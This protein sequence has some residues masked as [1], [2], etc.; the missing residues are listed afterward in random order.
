M[1]ETTS[2]AEPYVC[3]HCDET[4]EHTH[5]DPRELVLGLRRRLVTVTALRGILL[6]AGLLASMLLLPP[7]AV[8][9]FACTGVLAWALAM[10]AGLVAGS[11]DLNRRGGADA[12]KTRAAQERFM[13]VSV[14]AGAAA[15]PVLALLIALAGRSWTGAAGLSEAL[16]VAAGAGVGWL[17]VSV[18]VES[19]RS[20]RMRSLLGADTRA[21]E[22]AREAAVD[23]GGRTAQWR[24][25][26]TM[27]LTAVLVGVW[28]LGCF[29]MPLL[30]VVLV[31]LHLVLAVFS[32]RLVGNSA[33]ER[34]AG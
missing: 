1:S 7:T 14:L 8:L 24:E 23:M 10:A 16:G 29:L 21:G 2:P 12:A 6:V 31:P 11:V 15:T 33:A 32:R 13:T 27:V 34:S 3:P 19:V 30:V 25:L 26:V 22:G 4:H 9:T 5:V 17:A 18:I 20:M 28:V